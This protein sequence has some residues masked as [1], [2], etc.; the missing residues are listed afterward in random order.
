ME[1]FPERFKAIAMV[2]PET[3][4]KDLR[5]LAERGVVGVRFNLVSHRADAREG[6]G[7]VKLS[8]PFHIS[9][10]PADYADLDP[11]TDAMLAAFGSSGCIWGSDWPFLN[12][13]G[14]YRYGAARRAVER[15]L[16]DLQ[17]RESV[18]CANPQR[19]FGF[20]GPP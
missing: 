14:G 6:N 3:P 5:A 19:L 10:Q 1:R 7:A 16:I 12:L 11:F 2:D 20:G 9:R 15:W 17:R 8:A 18:L 4:E 13:A